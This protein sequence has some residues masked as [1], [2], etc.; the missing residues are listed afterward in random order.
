MQKLRFPV[1][2][3]PQPGAIGAKGECGG[4][5][6]TPTPWVPLRTSAYLPQS[7][8]RTPEAFLARDVT[9]KGVKVRSGHSPRRH[10]GHRAAV[11]SALELSL[12]ARRFHTEW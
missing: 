9:T 11:S 2:P 7:R 4:A 5:A 3:S 10:K 8:Y 12:P 6:G 1:T